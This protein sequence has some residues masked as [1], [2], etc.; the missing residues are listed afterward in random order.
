MPRFTISPISR[1]TSPITRC[2]AGT[3]HGLGRRDGLLAQLPL[4]EMHAGH[5]ARAAG[6]RDERILIAHVAQIDTQMRLAQQH[7]LQFRYREPVARMD[8][9]QV[10]GLRENFVD[11]RLELLREVLQLRAQSRLQPLARPDELLAERG[12]LRAAPLLPLH[13]RGAEERGPF[14]DQVPAVP[15][16]H[17]RAVGGPCDLAGGAD[18]IQEIQHHQHRLPAVLPAEAPDGLDVDA[19][20]AWLLSRGRLIQKSSVES[21]LTISNNS[22]YMAALRSVIFVHISWISISRNSL[23]T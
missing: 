12:E 16:G 11:L 19:Y 2:S 6:E 9:H 20:L 7:L 18:L 23:A 4:R 3:S 17:L 8:S 22:S 10:R 5:F 21:D 1:V 14:L 15:V 13:Q